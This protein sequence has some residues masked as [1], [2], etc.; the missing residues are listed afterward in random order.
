VVT[1]HRDWI[2]HTKYSNLSLGTPTGVNVDMGFL[3]PSGATS[4]TLLRT[5]CSASLSAAAVPTSGS[6][7]PGWETTIEVGVQWWVNEGI[8]Q[9]GVG[10][11][12]PW[13]SVQGEI[14]LLSVATLSANSKVISPVDLVETCQWQNEGAQIDTRAQRKLTPISNISGGVLAIDAGGNLGQDD[15]LAQYLWRYSITAACLVQWFS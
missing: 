9:P 13:F 14:P 3:W 5:R 8:I 11:L 1:R 15:G 6:V 7:Q 10:V 2:R 12:D 4:A